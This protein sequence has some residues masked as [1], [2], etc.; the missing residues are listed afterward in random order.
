LLKLVEDENGEFELET[1]NCNIPHRYFLNENQMYRISDLYYKYIDKIVLIGNIDEKEY[2]KQKNSMLIY[3]GG[4][5]REYEILEYK[6]GD[7]LKSTNTNCGNKHTWRKVSGNEKLKVEIDVKR[8]SS[9]K[10]EC[11]FTARNYEKGFLGIWYWCT[12][13]MKV[14]VSLDFKY[15]DTTSSNG[16]SEWVGWKFGSLVHVDGYNNAQHM[17]KTV[18]ISARFIP[19]CEDCYPVFTNYKVWADNKKAPTLN[20]NCN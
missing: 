17:S 19:T 4:T 15:M 6:K 12:R 16:Q 18:E 10:L 20:E 9:S 13:N 14:D 8:K 7:N 5:G 1:K 3:D 11:N 2:L